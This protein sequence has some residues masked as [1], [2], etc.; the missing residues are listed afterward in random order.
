MIFTKSKRLLLITFAI[1]SFLSSVES[2][3]HLS[4]VQ[5]GKWK[6]IKNTKAYTIHPSSL[7]LRRYST[8][9]LEQ[10]KGKSFDNDTPQE[11]SNEKFNE[12]KHQ[13]KQPINSRRNFFACTSIS[14]LSPLLPCKP[15]T[16][17]ALGL[18]QFPCKGGLYNNYHL[19]TAGESLMDSQ[20]IWSTNPLFLTSRE[21]ALSDAGVEQ[22]ERACEKIRE[23]KGLVITTVRYSLAANCMDSAN[24]I[25]RELKVRDCVGL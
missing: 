16:A 6:V 24:I 4:T 15:R 10:R 11:S 9:V 8:L 5:I 23:E 17:N 14:L 7:T 25:G 1:L 21:S 13:K 12:Q 22:I 2:L 19:L 3:Q 18:V 20:N